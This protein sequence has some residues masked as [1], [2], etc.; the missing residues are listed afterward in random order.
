MRIKSFMELTDVNKTLSLSCLSHA[1]RVRAGGFPWTSA[2]IPV[3]NAFNYRLPNSDLNDERIK[4]FLH[5]KQS[6]GGGCKLS[7]QLPKS[8]HSWLTLQ[9]SWLFL[10]GK[11]MA[12]TNIPKKKRDKNKILCPLEPAFPGKEVP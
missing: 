3:K 6:G 9:L 4:K 8:G 7:K 11:Q 5:N 10:H 12:S 2:F 1:S